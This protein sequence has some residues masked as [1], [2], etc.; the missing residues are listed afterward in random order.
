MIK[1]EVMA[2]V[3][4]HMINRTEIL[5]PGVLRFR[6]FDPGVCLCLIKK[7]MIKITIKTQNAKKI[8]SKTVSISVNM[9]SERR[10]IYIFWSKVYHLIIARYEVIY[11]LYPPCIDCFILHNDIWIFN[12]IIFFTLS[13][14][15]IDIKSFLK[16]LSG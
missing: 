13:E 10:N 6:L 3:K 9:A 12:Y 5:D 4:A 14:L 11:F 2:S 15:E 1:I 8:F 16:V 7:Y